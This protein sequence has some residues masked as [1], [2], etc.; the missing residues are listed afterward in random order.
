MW[1]WTPV[2][3]LA[4]FLLMVPAVG[5]QGGSRSTLAE[6]RTTEAQET[7]RQK[8]HDPGPVDGL[9]GPR[10]IAAVKAFQKEHGLPP[11]GQLDALTLA[12]LGMRGIASDGVPRQESEV[13]QRPGPSETRTGAAPPPSA[14]DPAQAHK[15]G[16]NVGEGASYSRSTE[17][18]APD[19]RPK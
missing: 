8:G 18:P 3:S 15:T 2:A 19:P 16:A 5:A 12:K 17:K 11:T 10:T 4:A 13:T 9:M 14:A 7:L 1:T 6:T